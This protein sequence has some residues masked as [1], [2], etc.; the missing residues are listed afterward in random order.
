MWVVYKGETRGF[1][2]PQ[3]GE[4]T[5]ATDDRHLSGGVP[6]SRATQKLTRYHAA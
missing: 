3:R 5:F 2:A 4:V 1:V 6:E